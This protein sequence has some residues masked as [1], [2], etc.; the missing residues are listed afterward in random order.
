MND[1]PSHPGTSH[2]HSHSHSQHSQPTQPTA[3]TT[4][5]TTTTTSTT[6]AQVTASLMM[7]M[8]AASRRPTFARNLSELDANVSG[9]TDLAGQ[10]KEKIAHHRGTDTDPLLDRYDM[11]T[12]LGQYVQGGGEACDRRLL[13]SYSYYY[14]YCYC[15]YF[16]YYYNFDYSPHSS[17]YYSSDF[18]FNSD[19]D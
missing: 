5:A 2:S 4:P 6:T 16:D 8:A 1:N 10:P 15:Y 11:G 14:Y 12:M 3:T 19:S 17:D 7:M 18:F 9:S 13:T